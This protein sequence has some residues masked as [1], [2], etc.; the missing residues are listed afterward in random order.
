[1]KPSA[2][3]SIIIAASLTACGG[4]G[5]SSSAQN[6][7]PTP[8]P[9]AT[10]SNVA[11]L[12]QGVIT[13]FGSVIVNG[14]HYDMKGATIEV[15]GEPQTESDLKV[16]QVVTL[17]AT[18][19]KA[20]DH[21]KALS[22]KSDSRVAGPL[23]S[24]NLTAGLLVVAGVPVLLTADTFYDEGVTAETLKVGD[25]LRVSCLTNADGALEATRVDVKKSPEPGQ[26]QWAGKV[27]A[28]DT[29]AKTF[30]L[31]GK[32]V[33][34]SKAT[35]S[36]LPTKTLENDQFV[37]VHGSLQNGVL[38][39]N[40]NVHPGALGVKRHAEAKK[41]LPIASGGIVDN[42]LPGVSFTQGDVT[43]LINS[44]TQYEG[45]TAADLADGI[46]AKV[47]GV[48][49]E[50]KNLVAKRIKLI[51]Q[52]KFEDE[53]IVTAVDV[54]AKTLIVN[55]TTYEMS[56]DTFVQDDSVLK[57]RYF[58]L[59]DVKL[60]DRVHVRGYKLLKENNKLVATRVI[61]QKA[62]EMPSKA[63]AR[64]EIKGK[65]QSVVD[66]VITLDGRSIKIPSN[67]SVEGYAKAQAFLDAAVG[68]KVW[69]RGV[70]VNDEFVATFVKVLN[71]TRKGDVEDAAEK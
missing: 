3:L 59:A 9:I 4:G 6:T 11:A 16:G 40:G 38:V 66:G 68:L 23:D 67:L 5:S 45:G 2:V 20:G 62:P 21:V 28:L 18:N 33:D 69:V 47:N 7:P 17:E 46:A 63:P 60:G 29:T 31:N 48:F 52:V 70:K 1:M 61:R 24:I 30:S 49:D 43:V 58:N 8:T 27:T 65:V 22:L 39:A 51:F 15:D 41:D 19:E 26:V 34:Y 13:G 35:L 14:V 10:A 42:L 25:P 56:D 54:A 50:N 55:G 32:T 36:P 37:R 53:G 64:M 44:S 71:P 57:M 12:S